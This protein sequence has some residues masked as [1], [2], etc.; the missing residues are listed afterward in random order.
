MA[1]ADYLRVELEVAA[2]TEMITRLSDFMR[3]RSKISQVVYDEQ[4]KDSPGLLEAAQIL[5][6]DAAEARIEQYWEEKV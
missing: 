1:N 3:R 6:G 2:D 5:F 4:M